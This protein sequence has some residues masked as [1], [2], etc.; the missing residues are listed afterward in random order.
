MIVDGGLAFNNEKFLYANKFS[1]EA[2]WGGDIP[3]R[4]MDS[5]VVPKG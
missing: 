2:T 4:D 1:E 5:I 3:P